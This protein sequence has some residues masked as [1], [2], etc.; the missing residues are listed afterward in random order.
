MFKN[1]ERTN[2][3]RSDILIRYIS[4]VMTDEERAEL[5][6]LSEGCKIREG[7]KIISP[8]KFKCGKYIWIGENALLDASGGLEI[9]DHTTI[10]V[11]VYI[12]THSTQLQNFSLNSS[13][14]RLIERKPTKIGYGCYIVGPSVIYKGITIGNKVTVLPM[15][16]VTKDIPD[17]C[18]VSGSPAKII[19]KWTE[20]QIKK[21]VERILNQQNE[22]EIK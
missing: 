19:K 22:G 12:W 15:S 1:D 16:V 11:G 8:D 21:E 9:G 17:Y 18:V 10:G 4:S 2:K 6:G 7:A 5:F 3:L 20:K 14:K 13:D